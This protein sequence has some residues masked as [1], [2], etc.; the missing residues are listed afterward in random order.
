M[1]SCRSTG[2][3]GVIHFRAIFGVCAPNSY[4]CGH[5]VNRCSWQHMQFYKWLWSHF[6]HNIHNISADGVLRHIKVPQVWTLPF[7]E[8]W[9][10]SDGIWDTKLHPPSHQHHFH[11]CQQGIRIDLLRRLC[12]LQL[13]DTFGDNDSELRSPV[14]TCKYMY[15]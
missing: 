12:S 9:F 13:H 1:D 11:S 4:P 3:H 7:H 8:N 15:T 6:H 10:L 2:V 14:P 5:L